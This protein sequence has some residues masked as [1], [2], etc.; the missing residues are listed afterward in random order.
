M[1]RR[2]GSALA[3]SI[4][5]CG[6]LTTGLIANA[7]LAAA[8]RDAQTRR[9][10][11]EQSRYVIESALAAVRSDLYNQRY[12]LP[13]IRNHLLPG[14]S[15]AYT[16]T[17]NSANTPRTVRVTGTVSVQGRSFRF[18]QVMGWRRPPHPLHYAAY[19]GSISWS[20]WSSFSLTAGLNGTLGDVMVNNNVPATANMALRIRAHGDLDLTGAHLAAA[21]A[22]NVSG[23]IRPNLPAITLPTINWA[24]ALTSAQVVSVGSF[25]FTNLSFNS[26]NR[27]RFVTGNL[28]VGGFVSGWG[29]VFVTGRLRITDNLLYSSAA[30]RV[31]FVANEVEVD[32]NVLTFVGYYLAPTR[33]RTNG[34]VANG[35]GAIATNRL[36]LGGNL[37]VIHDPEL[38]NNMSAGAT[39]R[40]PGF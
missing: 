21:N 23:R 6:A 1:R 5:L 38:W 36:V 35:R 19:I 12:S 20:D 39:F 11:S 3:Y 28:D 16:V 30:S 4:I 33:F 7:A 17:D 24:A 8:M 34:A 2:R 22:S 14:A 27:F 29:T 13:A 40:V 32:S 25:S 10:R 18:D 31:V 37:A 15:V 26:T 9:E